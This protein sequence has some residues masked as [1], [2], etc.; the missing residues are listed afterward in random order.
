MTRVAMLVLAALSA[1]SAAQAGTA[2]V[3]WDSNPEPDIA[4]YFVSYGTSAGSYLYRFDAGPRT[5]FKFSGLP[6][7]TTFYFTVQAYNQAGLVSPRSAEVSVRL[8]GSAPTD[9]DGDGMS[10]A[11]EALYHISSASADDDG[12]GISNLIEYHLGTDPTLANSLQLAEGAT[13]FFTERIALA[14]AG[15]TPAEVSVTYLRDSGAPP[16]VVDYTVPAQGRYTVNVNAEPGLASTAVSSVVNVRKGGVVAERTMSW[17]SGAQ[18]G[19]HTAKAATSPST[20]WYF[21]E[22]NAGF[23]DTWFLVSNSN[24]TASNITMTFL[25]EDGQT[26]SRGYTVAANSRFSLLANAIPELAGQGFSTT[27]SS[28]LPV[29]AERAMYFGKP[30]WDGGHG[31]AG[32]TGASTNWFIAEGRTG[33][34]FDM[35]VLFS[36]PNSQNVTASVDYLL[37]GGGV[38]NRAYSLPPTSRVTIHVDDVAGLTDTDVSASI[39]ATAP[40]IVE[41]AMYWPGGAGEWTEAHDSFALKQLGTEWLLAEGEYGGGQ[42]YSTYVLLA[43]PGTSSA[44][45]TLR[46]LRENGL[47][48][49]ETTRVVAPKS[50]T[51]VSA[52]ELATTAGLGSGEKFGVYVVSTTPIAVERSMYWNGGGR[53]WG[54]GTNEVG[55]RIR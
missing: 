8:S 16:L 3:A 10:D 37:P 6:E 7:G 12:D 52:I 54:S 50:R 43:N 15:S 4:G 47:A 20:T 38:I 5:Q 41:R 27:V 32:T 23:F 11:F 46:F 1:A 18:A 48:P 45:V 31:T 17:Q 25:R 14:N 33:P 26:V 2:T 42:G 34:F 44:T 55:V 30:T 51:T 24:A 21:A 49:I 40:I 28:S 35:W 13:G 29:G 9:S 53:F 19:A 39:S 36:N 22:G